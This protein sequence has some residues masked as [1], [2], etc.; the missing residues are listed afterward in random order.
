MLDASSEDNVSIQAIRQWF[1]LHKSDK[2]SDSDC[3]TQQYVASSNAT[4]K[5]STNAKKGSKPHRLR[6]KSTNDKKKF[7]RSIEEMEGVTFE[8]SSDDETVVK[9]SLMQLQTTLVA[10]G[11]EDEDSPIVDLHTLVLEPVFLEETGVTME[12]G[13]LPNHALHPFESNVLSPASASNLNLEGESSLY[14]IVEHPVNDFSASSSSSTA[15]LDRPNSLVPVLLPKFE[16]D[17]HSPDPHPVEAEIYPPLPS[18]QDST[19]ATVPLPH[20][21]VLINR[22]YYQPIPAP[23]NVVVAQ[24]SVPAP[25]IVPFTEVAPASQPAS[26]AKLAQ[27][28][29]L[30]ANNSSTQPTALA[31]NVKPRVGLKFDTPESPP[32]K[33]SVKKSQNARN[34]SRSSSRT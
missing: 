32:S 24:S 1:A 2:H 21:P 4:K 16:D 27:L 34:R 8:N 13:D 14:D 22:S 30:A 25:T 28:I 26:S 7:L 23:H 19:T 10:E 31:A 3:H 33:K 15:L 6:L 29:V 11:S 17:P 9:Q 5:R 12:E 20:G 18:P